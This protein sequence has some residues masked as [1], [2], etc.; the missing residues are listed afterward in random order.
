MKLPPRWMV[1]APH[2]R[3][4]LVGGVAQLDPHDITHHARTIGSTTTAC[5]LAAHV[6]INFYDRPYLVNRMGGC[7]PCDAAVAAHVDGP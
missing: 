4:V 1:T 6:W 5:G 2:A 7:P 3:R